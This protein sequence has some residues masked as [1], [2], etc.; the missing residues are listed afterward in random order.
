M[1]G[2]RKLAGIAQRA[3]RGALLQQGSLLLGDSHVRL[4][5]FV[6]VPGAQRELLRVAWREG[7]ATA[8]AALGDDWSLSRLAAALVA[9]LPGAERLAGDAGERR[10]GI[11]HAG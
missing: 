4:A 10:L 6:R 3:V 1:L 8:G 9:E 7:A 11:A 2:G 5:D